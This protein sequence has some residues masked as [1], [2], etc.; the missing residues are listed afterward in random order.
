MVALI[1]WTIVAVI[2]LIMG[3]MH[4]KSKNVLGIVYGQ[5]PKIAAGNVKRYNHAIG[6]AYWGYAV[7]LELLGIPL[8]FFEQNDAAFVIPVLGV[9]FLT[10]A[11][12]IVF[13]VI[14]K[15]YEN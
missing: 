1:I 15:K 4:W 5:V 11:L 6:M 9:V 14:K 12:C 13:V 3:I 8:V 10:I 7:I 2:F